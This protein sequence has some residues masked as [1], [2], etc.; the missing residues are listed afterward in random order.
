[1]RRFN[2]SYTEILFALFFC[3]TFAYIAFKFFHFN[4]MDEWLGR[5]LY[6]GIAFF[7]GLD[8][9]EPK[10][11]P[12]VTLYGWATGLFYMFSG[13]GGTPD[14]AAL[15]AYL[16]NLTA[17]FIVLFFI[18]RNSA[19][20]SEAFSW[21]NSFEITSLIS[22][23]FAF[24]F[25]DPTTDSLYRIHSD[26]PALFFLLLSIGFLQLFHDKQ[27]QIYL[28]LVALCLCLAFWSKLPTLPSCVLPIVYFTFSR[29]WKSCKLYTIHLLAA[30]FLTGAFVSIYYGFNDS[31]FILFDHIS[32]NK[33]SDRNFLFNGKDATLLSMNYF[34]AIP[35]LFRFFILYLQHYWVLILGI[36]GIFSLSFS[37]QIDSNLKFLLRSL[38]FGYCLTLPLPVLLLLHILEALKIL[39]FL[40]IS[41]V[42]YQL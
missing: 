22:L 21:S 13:L 31:K 29:K 1:M 11:G 16:S 7:H 6:P 35:L 20:N 2:L 30:I 5:G 34:E 32:D 36:L 18:F 33:W 8:F 4:L 28:F 42:Y 39:C 14:Q 19:L 3:L 10:S 27:K 37:N 24:A 26:T 38:F 40:Q 15:I 12:H 23:V 41:L 17:I 9:Y 25:L